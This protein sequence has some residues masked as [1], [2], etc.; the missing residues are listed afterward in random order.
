MTRFLRRLSTHQTIRKERQIRKTKLGK[1]RMLKMLLHPAKV[2]RKQHLNRHHKNLKP[3]S[4]IVS[5]LLYHPPNLCN[6]T[7][8]QQNHV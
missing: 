8:Q 2:L 6:P 4:R 7:L 5:L 3:L 1:L